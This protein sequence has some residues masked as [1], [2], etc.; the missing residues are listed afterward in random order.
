MT[1][2]R[3]TQVPQISNRSSLDRVCSEWCFCRSPHRAMGISA[4]VIC[5]GHA[6]GGTCACSVLVSVIVSVACGASFQLAFGR[7]CF[8][9]STRRELADVRLRMVLA[10]A[11]VLPVVRQVRR[12]PASCGPRMDPRRDQALGCSQ[13]CLLVHAAARCLKSQFRS[14][15]NSVPAPRASVAPRHVPPF[16]TLGP[17]SVALRPARDERMYRMGPAGKWAR[18]T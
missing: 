13:R 1:A 6:C 11:E 7:V 5:S 8:R 15:Q 16:S 10:R 3:E 9:V 12:E 17:G 2:R 18:P 4:V 14:S